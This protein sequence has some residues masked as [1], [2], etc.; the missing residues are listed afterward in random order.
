MEKGRE[1]EKNENIMANENISTQTLVNLW[2]SQRV[3]KFKVQKKKVRRKKAA[4]I[5]E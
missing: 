4:T 3:E 2:L 5:S 1:S